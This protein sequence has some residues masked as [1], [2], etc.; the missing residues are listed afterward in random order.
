MELMH[1]KKNGNVN[2]ASKQERVQLI[3]KDTMVI[4]VN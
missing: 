3:I 4:I 1:P 2:I